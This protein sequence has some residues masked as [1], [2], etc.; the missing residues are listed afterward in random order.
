MVI[1][2]L[3]VIENGEQKFVDSA[4]NK[5]IDVINYNGT[6]YHFAKESQTVNGICENAVNEPIVDLSMTGVSIQSRLPEEYQQVEYIESTGQETLSTE[7]IDKPDTRI[8]LD[9]IYTS[10]YK[11]NTEMAYIGANAGNLL[12]ISADGYMSVAGNSSTDIPAIPNTRYNVI[13]NRDASGLR[14]G[15]INGV[16]KTGTRNTSAINKFFLVGLGGSTS[17]SKICGK[18]YSCKIYYQD[19]LERDMVP[20]YR[21]SD[22]KIGMYDLVNNVF[23]VNTGEGELLKGNAVPNTETPMEI[24]SVGDKTKNLLDEN[25]LLLNNT[26]NTYYSVDKDGVTL[27]KSNGGAWASID[28]IVTL[29]AGTYTISNTVEDVV[30]CQIYDENNNS[31]VADAIL[32]KTFTLGEKK[33]LKIKLLTRTSYPTFIGHV[34]IEQGE[35]ATVC[36]PFGYKIPI[37]VE[38]DLS[39]IDFKKEYYI[40]ANNNEINNTGYKCTVDYIPVSP[41]TEYEF[42]FDG[43]VNISYYVTIP[44]YDKDKGFISRLSGLGTFEVIPKVVK[45]TTPEN[46]YF[47]KFSMPKSQYKI[48]FSQ[49][50]N[51]YLNEPLRKVGNYADY[52]DYKNKKV[53]RNIYREFIPTIAGISSVGGTYKIFL[54]FMEKTPKE[55]SA[56]VGLAISN[57]FIYFD[58][59]Y[60]SL[61]SNGGYIQSYIT[62]AK[63]NRIAVTFNDVSIK[64]IEQAQ[65]KIG[66]GFE[67]CYVLATPEEE[68]IDIPEISTFDGTCTIS[69]ETTIKP[70]NFSADYWKQIGVVEETDNIVQTGS[71]ILIISTG[72]KITQSG[73]NLLIGG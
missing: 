51:I 15:V 73:T 63:L 64:T 45:F 39:D 6:D 21:I 26:T 13:L 11:V 7:Y 57:K 38:K 66:D 22:N 44:F 47:I 65:E 69:V 31:V 8:E 50:T 70:N 35:T 62:S 29:P 49:T 72:A 59:G 17:S 61:P 14:T 56:Y 32:P 67:I 9:F 37:K 43:P 40:D 71:N 68:T 10:I 48:I 16:E 2:E 53:I 19:K 46:C 23:Y 54:C 27:L 4:D 30:R 58:K 25:N 1:D 41:S 34:Q 12:T 5:I 28:C 18:I 33:G 42:Y 3:I 52:I 60:S 24:E 20:C 36:E 55:P